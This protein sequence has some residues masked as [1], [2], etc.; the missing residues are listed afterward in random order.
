MAVEAHRQADSAEYKE[1]MKH[2]AES[3]YNELNGIENAEDLA[4]SAEALRNIVE[5]FKK[6]VK[7]WLLRHESD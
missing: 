3:V 6:H 4:K 5:S 7:K 1:Y 2:L